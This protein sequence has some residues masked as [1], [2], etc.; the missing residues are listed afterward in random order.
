M[1]RHDRFGRGFHRY[2][3]D[4]NQKWN[5]EQSRRILFLWREQEGLTMSSKA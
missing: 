3:Q 1:D 2:Q 5:I 4:E